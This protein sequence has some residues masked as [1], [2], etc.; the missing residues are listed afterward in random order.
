MA[1]RKGFRGHM[2]QTLHSMKL[3]A[4]NQTDGPEVGEQGSAG[5]S[6]GSR[7]WPDKILQKV[8][9]RTSPPS[10]SIWLGMSLELPLCG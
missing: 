4:E 8:M 2:V 6:G 5:W 10:G 3:S 9:P 1:N 7:D